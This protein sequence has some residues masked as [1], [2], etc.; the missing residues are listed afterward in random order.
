VASRSATTKK[1]KAPG[2]EHYFPI[3]RGQ[4]F[5]VVLVRPPLPVRGRGTVVKRT[6]TAIQLRL[7][8][9]GGFLVPSISAELELTY[10]GEGRGNAG[11]LEVQVG[12]RKESFDDRD[13]TIHSQALKRSREISPSLA[14]RGRGAHAVLHASGESECRIA[15][16]GFELK[17]VA[18]PA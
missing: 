18:K 6:A 14:H 5:E 1:A 16:Q 15:A 12:A 9:P 3:P 17:L 8:V 10:S 13:V 2:W 4:A 7:E 11:H